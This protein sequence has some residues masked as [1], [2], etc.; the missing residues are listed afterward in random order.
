MSAPANCN[1]LSLDFIFKAGNTK[2][3]AVEDDI[4]EDL[5]K[6]GITVVPRPL[7][8]S[9]FDEDEKEG[10]FNLLFTGTWGAPYDPHTYLT[11]WSQ[12]AH[13]EYAEV[14]DLWSP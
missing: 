10:N 14:V 12:P 8:S 11:S 5:A 13:A 6:I 7:N 9:Q 4:A 3:E 2:L 1:S